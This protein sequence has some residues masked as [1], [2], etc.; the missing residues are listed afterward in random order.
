MLNPIVEV[1]QIYN[2]A[3]PASPRPLPERSSADDQDLRA[4]RNQH[5]GTRKTGEGKDPP[6]VDL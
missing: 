4:W 6:G 3:C 1:D 5:A 2:L